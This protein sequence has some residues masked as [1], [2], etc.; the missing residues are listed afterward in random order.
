MYFGQAHSE[1]P[2]SH[3]KGRICWMASV[4]IGPRVFF[5][6]SLVDVSQRD[7]DHRHS[8]SGEKSKRHHVIYGKIVVVRILIG[9][10]A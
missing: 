4:K 9:T 3:R 6:L 5:P 10:R 1:E 7:D 2:A 8:A